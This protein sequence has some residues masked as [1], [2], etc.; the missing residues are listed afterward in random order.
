[1]RLLRSLQGWFGGAAAELEAAIRLHESGDL[2]GA[3]QRYRAILQADA[4]D[5]DAMHLL[6]LIAHQRGEHASAVA[7]IGAAI[8]LRGDKAIY[9]YNLGNALAALDR[10]QAAAESF[11]AA[12]RLNPSHVAA[13]A[14]LAQALTQSGRHREAVAEFRQ[15]LR[16]QPSSA[17]RDALARALIRHA[18]TDPVAAQAYEEAAT[19]LQQAWQ[20]ADDPTE[21][22]LALAYCLQQS[23]R[24]TEA[25]DHYEAVV[26]IQPGNPAAHN[27]LANCYNQLGRMNEAI[28]HYRETYRLAPDFRNPGE[29]PRLPELRPGL[30][31]RAVG[32][33]TQAL[34]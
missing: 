30:H 23:K 26:A 19:L 13:R 28:R 25:A 7:Q 15:L 3:E 9:H 24:W 10:P 34:G 17:W 18:D 11:R 5:A 22:R 33:R 20:D 31:A 6:G 2:D 8:A 4:R 1:M 12:T 27:N 32:G 16:L 21:A 29:F 14:N